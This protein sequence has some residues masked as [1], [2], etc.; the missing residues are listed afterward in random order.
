MV[1]KSKSQRTVNSKELGEVIARLGELARTGEQDRVIDLA[2][3]T[4]TELSSQG[5]RNL[6]SHLD[7]LDLRAE[8]FIALGKMDLAAKDATEM[9]RLSNKTDGKSTQKDPSLVAMALNRKALVQMRQGDLPSALKTATTA[10]KNARQAD[11]DLLAVS[12]FRLSEAQWRSG[13]PE[14]SLRTSQEALLLFQAAGDLSGGGRVYWSICTAHANLGHAEEAR[15]YALSALELCQ[16]AGDQYGIGNALNM[17]TLVGV[18]IA[19]N[20]GYYQ[21]ALQAFELAGYAERQAVILHNLGTLYYDLGLYPHAIRLTTSA[22]NI[23]RNSGANL[24]VAYALGN[25]AD[26]AIIIGDLGTARKFAG[27]LA[28]MIPSL[29]DPYMDSGIAAT[30]GELA[31]ADGDPAT[32]LRYFK[33]SVQIIHQVGLFSENAS[34]TQ[35]ANAYLVKGNPASALTASKKA[36]H[37]HEFKWVCQARWT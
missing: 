20:I 21:Q 15:R 10:V 6:H 29:G 16:Q 2:S 22:L 17:L 19:E 8:S 7:L 24:G 1:V 9:V 26:A 11:P 37:L 34:L 28:D 36:T 13:Q 25:L 5:K 30:W 31:L 32:A 27:E 3:Q 12:L 18:D 14:V 23:H 35:L 4:L 33:S